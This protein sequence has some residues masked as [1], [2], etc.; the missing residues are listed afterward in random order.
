MPS[1]GARHPFAKLL[2]GLKTRGVD[3]YR[4]A[5]LHQDGTRAIYM[6]VTFL[7]R[8]ASSIWEFL[9]RLP[10]SLAG[11]PAPEHVRHAFPDLVNTA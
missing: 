5:V 1:C 11:Q 7:Q 4:A 2:R 3:P 6:A 9:K 8:R 10:D